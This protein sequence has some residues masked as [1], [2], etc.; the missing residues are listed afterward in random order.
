MKHWFKTDLELEIEKELI[1]L[2]QD[3]GTAD[4]MGGSGRWARAKIEVW[5]SLAMV[6][7]TKYLVLATGGLI[8]ATL[9]LV[10][11]AIAKR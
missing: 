11:A 10:I 7:A 6:R 8:L 5:G 1:S 4:D 3:A 9:V 2:I